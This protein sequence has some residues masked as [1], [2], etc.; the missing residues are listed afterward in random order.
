M[1]VRARYRHD[2]YCIFRV[3]K[4]CFDVLYT[5]YSVVRRVSTR[6]EKGLKS[7]RDQERHQP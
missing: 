1:M 4:I 6:E 3:Y 2:L 5:P 7:S